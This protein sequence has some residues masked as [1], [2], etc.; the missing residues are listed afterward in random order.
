MSL[1]F[2]SYVNLGPE[3]HVLSGVQKKKYAYIW[4]KTLKFFTKIIRGRIIMIFFS[5]SVG[6]EGQFL[7]PREGSRSRSEEG[8]GLP[9]HVLMYE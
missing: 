9:P 6:E 5:S 2:C 4:R 1:L 7:Q 8:G 3:G